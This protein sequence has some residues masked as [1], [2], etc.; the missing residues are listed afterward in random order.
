[1]VVVL[2][3]TVVCVVPLTTVVPLVAVS[4]TELS[5]AVVVESVFVFEPTW[6]VFDVK[7]LVVPFVVAELATLLVESFCVEEFVAFAD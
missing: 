6:E 7:S 4:P 1:V 5:A 2:V 3:S